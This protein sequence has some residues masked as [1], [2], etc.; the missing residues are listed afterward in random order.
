LL[1]ARPGLTHDREDVVLPMVMS[2]ECTVAKKCAVRTDKAAENIASECQQAMRHTGS[3]SASSFR[4]TSA[5]R[6]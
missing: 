3:R 1:R 4:I 5:I 6:G 2:Q